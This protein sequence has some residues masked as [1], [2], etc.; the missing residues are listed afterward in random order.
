MLDVAMHW[1]ERALALEPSPARTHALAAARGA[2]GLPTTI[3]PPAPLDRTLARSLRAAVEAHAWDQVLALTGPALTTSPHHELFYWTGDAL[4]QQGH[5]SEARRM[6]SRARTLLRAANVAF[7]PR[8]DLPASVKQLAWSQGGLALVRGDHRWAWLEVWDDRLERPWRRW[9][10]PRPHPIAWS[11][12]GTLLAHGELVL[13]TAD[14][15]PTQTR[16]V[17]RDPASGATLAT[18]LPGPEF[19]RL[20]GAES[21]PV[22][23]TSDARTGELHT[24]TWSPVTATLLASHSF[25]GDAPSSFALDTAGTHLAIARPNSPPRLI[26]LA[27]GE[28]RPLDDT[29]R[30]WQTL[31]FLA[32]D[33]LL[34]VDEHGATLHVTPA[35]THHARLLDAD[36][37]HGYV[38]LRSLSISPQ[39][40]VA[41]VH[42]R[43]HSDAHLIVCDRA[44]CQSTDIFHATTTA[45]SPDGARLASAYG[46]EL[47]VHD[48]PGLLPAQISRKPADHLTI[49]GVAAD[50]SVIAVEA[51]FRGLA[52]WDTRT[53]ARLLQRRSSGFRGFSPDGRHAALIGA[54]FHRIELHPLA[55]GSA[56]VFDTA[57]EPIDSLAFSP[58]GRRLAI[59]TDRSIG[60]WDTTDGAE[61]WREAN[62]HHATQL[63]FTATGELLHSSELGLEI[64]DAAGTGRPRTLLRQ[65]HGVRHWS[66]APGGTRVVVCA[67]NDLGSRILDL[68]AGRTLR[69]LPGLCGA[70]FVSDDVLMYPDPLFPATLD[71]RTGR[72]HTANDPIGR[73]RMQ[74]LASVILTSKFD[75]PRGLVVLSPTGEL[76]ATIQAR[77]DLGWFV[78]T[79]DGAVDGDPSA[80]AAVATQVDHGA[81]SQLH[82]AALAW[83]GAHVP[84]LL[85]RVIAGERVRP[86]TPRRDVLLSSPAPRPPT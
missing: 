86:P 16:L 47:S 48:V 52:I 14:D 82:P 45:F 68:R 1:R 31:R 17:L 36:T 55:G 75:D 59:T 73:T 8:H 24:W 72:T 57:G 50:G 54:E 60:V 6:W 42:R 32:D 30:T 39:G 69:R 33:T 38:Q 80:P 76:R 64:R 2:L 74:V 58:D 29:I 18:T 79:V 23:A 70:S 37:G 46:P 19:D 65:R 11:A 61:L 84:G 27:T 5:P 28:S 9:A 66:L 12:D 71:L 34:A 4:W 41:G 53:G 81:A 15:A 78:D 49:A 20:V 35:Q 25:T 22:F 62:P 63:A 83:D 67:D 7:A 10:V 51:R 44:V 26:T 56:E 13:P 3:T 77:E 43:D 40:Q 85:P 21:A